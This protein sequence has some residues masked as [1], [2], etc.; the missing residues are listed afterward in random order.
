MD[1][2]RIVQVMTNLC[3]NALKFTKLGGSI[4]VGARH[5]NGHLRVSVEDSVIGIADENLRHV[6]DRLVGKADVALS[7]RGSVYRSPRL[8][9]MPT[10]A[11]SGSRARWERAHDSTS[12]CASRRER[13]AVPWDCRERS[14]SLGAARDR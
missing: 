9:S 13:M 10:E 8:S 1:S 2:H 11:T 7:A 12:P 6:F 5:E 14:R 3:A 4:V